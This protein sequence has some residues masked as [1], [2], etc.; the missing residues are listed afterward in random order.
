M[1][2]I[3]YMFLLISILAVGCSPV[4]GERKETVQDT[5][6]KILL[7]SGSC[8]VYTFCDEETGVWY[9]ATSE[10]ITPRLQADKTLFTTE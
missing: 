6:Y 8:F 9:I 5:N 10:G 3:I 1:K 7:N 4:K 2:K